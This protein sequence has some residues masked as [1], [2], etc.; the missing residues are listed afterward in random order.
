MGGI[1]YQNFHQNFQQQFSGIAAG[2]PTASELKHDNA[3]TPRVGILWQPQHWLSLY[4]N[5]VESYGVNFGQSWVSD[6]QSKPVP[7]T[8]ATQYEG[9]IKTEF[10]N[11]RLRSNLAYFDLVKT[12]ISTSDLAHPGFVL[13]TGAVQSR[14][15]EFDV[16]GEILPGWNAIATYSNTDAK[17]IKSNEVGAAGSIGAVGSRFWGVPR[18]TASLWNTYELQQGDIKG[19]KFGGGVT[20]RNGQIA[21][22]D[23]PAY[24]LPGYVTVDVLAAYSRNVGKAKVT[25]QLNVNN[26][27]DKSYYTGLQTYVNSGNNAAFLDFGMP[28]TFMGSIGI[29][30]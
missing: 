19:L 27:L 24:T 6:T 16:T 3:V 4:T 30:F 20:L 8:S 25:L 29:Q 7:S 22:C 23:A 9:G 15:Y 2:I 12:N 5:Y 26:L 17:T 21:C 14:G 10:F 18:N 28:R 13:V 1:R 11:G